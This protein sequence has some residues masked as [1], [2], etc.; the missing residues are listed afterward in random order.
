M[1]A[2][3]TATGNSV[4]HNTKFMTTP[5]LFNLFSVHWISVVN[6]LEKNMKSLLTATGYLVSLAA[7]FSIVT[8][9][10]RGRLQATRCDTTRNFFITSQ[11]AKLHLSSPIFSA[12]IG[13]PYKLKLFGEERKSAADRGVTKT[14]T[15]EN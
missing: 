8:Q 12:C 5:Q 1:K 4:R 10:L 3:L 13:C 9:R 2:L 7:V 11:H 14:K 6:C 15:L